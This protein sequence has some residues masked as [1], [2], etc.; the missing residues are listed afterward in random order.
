MTNEF[1]V[2]RW[3]RSLPQWLGAWL[4]LA[5]LAGNAA[6]FSPV[7]EVQ[8]SSV[9]LIT[10]R[11]F[12][13][14]APAW[15]EQRTVRVRGTVTHV[16]SD[17]TFFIQD[18]EAGTYV[19]H[20]P[21]VPHQIGEMVEVIGLPSLGGF[22]PTLHY[23]D[24]RVVGEG[25][26]VVPVPIS[27]AD[28]MTGAYAMRLVTVRGYLSTE[29]LRSGRMMVINPGD[30]EHAFTADLESEPQIDR[31]VPLVFENVPPTARAPAGGDGLA[32]PLGDQV[33]GA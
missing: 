3:M 14:E 5:C 18:G 30:G 12:L 22:S 21:P 13:D 15:G 31:R 1:N 17:R 11:A 16:I 24:S 4:V 7:S 25:K 29:R 26:K 33:A 6:E 28:A 27:P 20:K 9:P 32:R 23:C 19:F 2:G 8:T 10:I